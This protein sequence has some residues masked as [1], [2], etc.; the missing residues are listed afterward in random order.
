MYHFPN[1]FPQ[2]MIIATGSSK[3]L[4][5]HNAVEEGVSHMWTVSA[6]QLHPRVLIV[7]D[8]DATLELKVETVKYFKVAQNHSK[9][10]FILLENICRRWVRYIR[11]WLN[12]IKS[13]V[14]ICAVLSDKIAQAGV[15][16]LL[17]SAALQC[18]G[19]NTCLWW[20]HAKVP[21][22]MLTLKFLLMYLFLMWKLQSE[23][24]NFSKCSSL[25]I[26]SKE[27]QK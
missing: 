25:I 5:L 9:L 18:V 10:N 11:S 6:L 1:L 14:I 15:T 3:A 12:K 21:G 4:A 19:N 26:R 17:E 27:F 22:N 16:R 24:E 2:V 20:C 13:Y 23:G 8:E 7:C